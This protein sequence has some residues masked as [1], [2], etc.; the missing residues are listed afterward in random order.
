MKTM[1]KT[2]LDGWYEYYRTPCPICGHTGGCMTHENGEVVACIRI[3][4]EKPFSKNSALPSYLHFLKGKPRNQKIDK[5]QVEEY[6]LHNKKDPDILNEVYRLFLDCLELSDHHYNHLTSQ[7]QLSDRQIKIREYRS[8]PN[9]PWDVVSMMKESGRYDEFGG[10]PGFYLKENK[11]WTIA[12]REGILIPFRNQF[13]QIIG[14]QYRIDSPPNVVE[15][16]AN[17]PNFKARII[18][19]PDLVRVSVDEEIIFE[20]KIKLDKKWTTITHGKKIMGWIRVVKGNRYYWLSSANKPQGTSS[21]DPAPI[22]I[23]VP[24]TTLESWQIGKLHKA[25]TVWLSEGPLKCDIAADCIAKLYDPLELEDIGT[26]FIAL[27]GV[28]A[29]RLAIPIMREM[30]VEKVNICFDADAVSNIHVKKHLLECAKELKKEGFQGNLVL[31]NEKE[32][33]GIDD[34][35]LIHKLPQ[36]RKL[37]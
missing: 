19:Q 24:T 30:G 1:R 23:A 13:N 18:K 21:G 16:K 33:K 4:S 36:L 17:C 27:P 35:L 37:F 6:T 20:D 10:I 9:K 12:G 2:R 14:F 8:F 29:W 25:R 32:G 3:E 34:L 22:H 28:G 31:W 15:I 7:R 26:T 11:Y 5:N